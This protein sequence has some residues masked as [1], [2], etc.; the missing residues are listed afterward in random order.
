MPQATHAT[1][2]SAG[3]AGFDG[4]LISNI[5]LSTPIRGTGVG[6]RNDTGTGIE[7]QVVEALKALK[8]VNLSA[9]AKSTA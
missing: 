5:D 1:S 2:A 4:E 3:G 7:N 9:S 8:Q 6:E